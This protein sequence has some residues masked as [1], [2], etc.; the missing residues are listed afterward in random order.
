M[1]QPIVL[2]RMLDHSKQITRDFVD[3]FSRN[4]IS[5]IILAG[6]GSSY[7]AAYSAKY[8]MQKILRIQVD[9]Q[10]AHSFTNY[11]N[12][13]DTETL[14]VGISQSGES[15]AAVNS[16]M[17]AIECG[18]PTIAVT[19]EEGSYITEHTHHVMIVPSGDEE[20]GA[21]TKGY[22]ATVLAFYLAALE[23][24]RHLNLLKEEEYR[25]CYNS[26]TTTIESIPRAI[27]KADEWYEKNR[28]ELLQAKTLIVSGYGNN[29]GTA[30]E[31]GL[32]FLETSRFPVSVYELEEFM[33][34]PYNAID[35][36]SYIFFIV[37]RGASKERALRL[38]E[39]FSTKTNHSYMVT[40]D[41]GS[42]DERNVSVSFHEDEDFTP[43][44]YIVPLQVLFFRLAKDKQVDMKTVRY[45]D[46]HSFMNSKRRFE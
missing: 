7:N 33:H 9:V 19:S 16:I 44:E 32:K 4:K 42:G 28:E 41:D 37:P 22:T 27:K 18:L 17:K 21:T 38:N 25:S 10:T 20:A 46:F 13:I 14:V 11:E 43:I 29:Y 2:T 35:E 5:R 24:A 45:P 15:T 8:F 31:A 6:S 12:V 1:E 23:T 39:Y 3:I 30:L 26:L 34:G 36:S 40:Q